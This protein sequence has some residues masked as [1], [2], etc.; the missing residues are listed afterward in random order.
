MNRRFKCKKE[1]NSMEMADF[2]KALIDHNQTGNGYQIHLNSDC[3]DDKS[4]RNI[5]IEIG[6]LYFMECSTLKNQ[7]LLCFG[8]MSKKPIEQAEDGTNLYPIEINSNMFID[9]SKIESIE[10]V[11]DFQ[12]WFYLPSEK[13]FNIYMYSE[14]DSLSGNRNVITVGFMN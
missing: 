12:D 4:A 14:N 13:V 9:I 2:L 11:E 3:L 7:T 10:N 6:D 8:N 1:I 5:G